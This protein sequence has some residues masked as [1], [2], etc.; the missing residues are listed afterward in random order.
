MTAKQFKRVVERN[1][2]SRLPFETRLETED[3]VWFVKELFE[4]NNQYDVAQKLQ[5]L[6]EEIDNLDT[7]ELVKE[8]VFD[9]R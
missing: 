7:G 8:K 9:G 6:Y 5:E 3:A 4:I 1:R 2:S